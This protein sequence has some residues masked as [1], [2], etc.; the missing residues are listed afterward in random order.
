[1][2]SERRLTCPLLVL[3]STRGALGSWYEKEGGPLGLWQE[4][5]TGVQGHGLDAG[6]FFPEEMPSETAEA[7]SRFFC[8]E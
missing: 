8:P 7:L 2:A 4:W 6:H 3:G 1:V 5:S